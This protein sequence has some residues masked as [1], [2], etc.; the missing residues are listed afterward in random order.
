MLRALSNTA[1]RAP[2]EQ[3][4][5]TL[6]SRASPGQ[7]GVSAAHIHGPPPHTPAALSLQTHTDSIRHV[8]PHTLVL[9]V[10]PS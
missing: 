2:S 9:D 5:T 3:T 10:W 6:A 1:P 7:Q 8:G 4:H